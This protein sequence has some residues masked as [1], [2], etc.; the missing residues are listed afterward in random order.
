MNFSKN[1]ACG[2][3][4]IEYTIIVSCVAGIYWVA[5]YADITSLI[6]QQF[7]IILTLINMP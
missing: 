6:R 1:N 4:A 7:E 3:A 5:S 2:F